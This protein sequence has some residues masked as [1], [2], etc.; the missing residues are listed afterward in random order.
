MG[1]AR[2]ANRL[3][4]CLPM[5]PPRRSTLFA[6]PSCPRCLHL[7]SV[8]CA[9]SHRL[10]YCPG[11]VLTH[12]SP[13]AVAGMQGV[14]QQLRLPPA[15][16]VDPGCL[17]EAE[18]AAAGIQRLPATLGEAIEAYEADTGKQLAAGV[19]LLAAEG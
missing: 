3:A 12:L 11:P 6:A 7:L 2:E 10:P 13:L 18:R 17:T 8:R 5:G 1:R 19:E 15:V 9:A 14:R 4:G 16:A